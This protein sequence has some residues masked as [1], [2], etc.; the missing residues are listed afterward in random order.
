MSGGPVTKTASLTLVCHHTC[1]PNPLTV[2]D[3]SEC[4]SNIISKYLL[5]SSPHPF[6]GMMLDEDS[7]LCQMKLSCFILCELQLTLFLEIVLEHD[8]FTSL[9]SHI[10][11]TLVLKFV[12]FQADCNIM[13]VSKYLLSSR[14]LTHACSNTQQLHRY[15]LR[16]PWRLSSFQ[17]EKEEEAWREGWFDHEEDW[18]DFPRETPR[19][20]WLWS[21]FFFFL[22]MCA[23]LIWI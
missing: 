16:S 12:S 23:F 22:S 2:A 7:G 6:L 11:D 8:M 5:A 4:A 9:T 13:V 14:L 3:W 15:F 21:H 20:G 17:Q 19:W 1:A 10:Y 18:T